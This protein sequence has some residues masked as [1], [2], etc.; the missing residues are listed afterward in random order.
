MERPQL[1]DPNA[2]LR[3][4][5]AIS[6]CRGKVVFEFGCGLGQGSA[7]ISEVA[8][9]VTAVDK[10]EIIEQ[11]KAK[12]GK[13]VDFTTSMETGAAAIVVALEVIEHLE[14]EELEKLLEQWSSNVQEI[15]ATTPH[16]D[17]FPHPTEFHKHHYTWKELH[18]LF[19]KYYK[20]V[21]ITGCGY[22]PNWKCFGTFI[23]YGNNL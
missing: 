23:I 6:Y 17:L 7:M 1:N 10:P 19:Q 21:V 11:A 14:K 4:K 18:E 15:L 13:H 3:Y 9:L 2:I 5:M 20:F 16:G 12:Y 8:A 22:D